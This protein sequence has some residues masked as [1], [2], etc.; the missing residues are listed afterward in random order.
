MRA[1]AS[2]AWHSLL[3]LQ[4]P[5]KRV[6]VHILFTANGVN[7]INFTCA[8]VPAQSKEKIRKKTMQSYL[9]SSRS[10]S[11][12]RQQLSFSQTTTARSRPGLSSTLVLHILKRCSVLDLRRRR[13]RRGSVKTSHKHPCNHAKCSNGEIRKPDDYQSQVKPSIKRFTSKFKT[14]R[15]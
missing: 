1:W 5:G 8:W 15:L 10:F 14:I 4:P 2:P 13:R 6:I 9:P 12:A 7:V 3:L 11:R